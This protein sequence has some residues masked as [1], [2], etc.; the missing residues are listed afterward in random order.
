[1]SAALPPFSGDEPR[2]VKCGNLG[3]FTEFEA[4]QTLGGAV[5][6]DEKLLRRCTRCGYEWDE[7][8]VQSDVEATSG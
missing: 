3:A 4:A 5:L 6:A 1:M 8:I 7:A 2:C